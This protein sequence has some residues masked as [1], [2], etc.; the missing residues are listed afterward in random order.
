MARFDDCLQVVLGFEG[1]YSHHEADRG[2][3]TNWG[4]TEAT[5]KEA[6]KRGIVSH[7]DIARLRSHE[8]A[9]IYEAMYWTPSRADDMPQPLDLVVFDC[10]VNHGVGGAGRLLQ[11]TVN[12][13]MDIDLVV[14]GIVG[15]ATQRE[16]MKALAVNR[17]EA[18]A[19]A[20]LAMRGRYFVRIV[21]GNSS[22]R[23]FFWG[24]VRQRVAN[25]IDK[26]RR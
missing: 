2:G 6:R 21:E 25:L 20:M 5:L 3:R 17:P 13:V 22:Q 10:A 23:A 18:L 11:Q 19:L 8:A 12:A 7:S 4:I 16:L 15:P 14:D 1:G 24:W 26:L 9:A